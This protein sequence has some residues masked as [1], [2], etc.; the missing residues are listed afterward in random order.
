MNWR[1]KDALSINQL[2]RG[3][4]LAREVANYFLR[5][6]GILTLGTGLAHGFVK[7]APDQPTPDAQYFFMHASYANAAERILDRAPGMTIGVAQLRPQSAGSI[8]ARS[9]DPLAKPAIRPNMLSHPEDQRCLVEAMKIARR[10]VGQPAM[11][12][13]VVA[14]LAPG[15]EVES[16]EAWLEF[17]RVNAQTI[18]HPIGTCRMGEDEG[19]V[20]D[21][22]LRVR[23]M[24]GLR[25]IDAS[26]IPRM[27]S[28]NT[29]VAVLVVAERGA[30]LVLA[31]NGARG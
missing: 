16:D 19:A 27:V 9:R 29:Q 8:H 17:G 14:E 18:Y 4:R 31:S 3:W 20:V 24:Q 25:V 30:E 11:R 5:R 12:R 15:P 1:V 21:S 23:G 28:G 10:I 22:Q 26:V 7:T 13:H 2:S 6:R